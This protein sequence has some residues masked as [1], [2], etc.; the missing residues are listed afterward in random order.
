MTGAKKMTADMTIATIRAGFGSR[1][2]R[3]HLTKLPIF[4][5]ERSL[6]DAISDRLD[7]LDK[8]EREGARSR[9]RGGKPTT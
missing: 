6:P 9:G 3:K 1:E 4:Q 2:V 5:V 8:A 7:R